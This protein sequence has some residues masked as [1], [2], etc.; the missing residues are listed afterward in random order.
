MN[1]ELRDG[2]WSAVSPCVHRVHVIQ[3]MHS[4]SWSVCVCVCD[5]VTEFERVLRWI[6]SEGASVN[7]YMF[8]GGTNFGFL[9]GANDR[10]NP[11]N[12]SYI[13]DYSPVV[14]SYGSSLIA[15]CVISHLMTNF[16]V[17]RMGDDTLMRMLLM[18]HTC[19]PSGAQPRFQSWGSNSL[20]DV[21]VQ[22]K[23]RMVYP[24]SCTDT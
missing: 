22:N 23:I 17:W 1:R 12:E 9:A 18:V 21:I 8:H 19:L 4:T 20:V 24:V 14:T 11:T 16:T 10:L 3:V 15:L 5:A 6:L 7:F 13:I 2:E